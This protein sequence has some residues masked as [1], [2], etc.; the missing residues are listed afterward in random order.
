MVNLESP[1]STLNCIGRCY[2]W[3][4]YAF[5]VLFMFSGIAA[6]GVGV[7]GIVDNTSQRI[8]VLTNSEMYVNASFCLIA[9]GSAAVFVSILGCCAVR[10]ES[11][12]LIFAF[13]ALMMLIFVTE[14]AGGVLSLAYYT[15]V[16]TLANMEMR[17]ALVE[18]YGQ[19]TH[20]ETTDA[21]NYVQLMFDCCG[22][23]GTDIEAAQLYQISKWFENNLILVP[24]SCC[25]RDEEGEPVNLQAC[26][27][28]FNTHLSYINNIGCR[29]AVAEEGGRFAVV[30]A[31]TGIG[32]S[33]L[34]IIGMIL[35]FCL[36][37]R[38]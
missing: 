20:F 30:I 17:E 34:Q 4:L 32:V 27:N 21:F 26:Q 36:Y 29:D 33:M 15:Q 23:E 28:M 7:W 11:K 5:N 16:I 24:P 31:G 12:C 3:T 2:K 9:A 6:M 13:A 10:L 37:R 8:V 19:G 25:T 38:L 22:F 18:R 35:A 1:V 14:F